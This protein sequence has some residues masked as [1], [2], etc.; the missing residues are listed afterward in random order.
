MGKK[1]WKKANTQSK[2]VMTI[3]ILDQVKAEAKLFTR[4]K[5][6]QYID[7]M[8]HLAGKHNFSPVG[9]NN[10]ALKCTK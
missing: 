10:I 7:K 3:L 1:G 8:F 6:G 4:N 9:P 5:E 2:A